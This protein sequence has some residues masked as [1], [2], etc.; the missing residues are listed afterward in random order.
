MK[1]ISESWHD[2]IEPNTK[3]QAAYN[4]LKTAIVTLDLPP[5]T[6]LVERYIMERFDLSRTPMREAINRLYIEGF[7]SNF[8]GKGFVV[9]DFQ[10]RDFIDMYEVKEALESEAAAICCS[11][12]IPSV[13]TQIEDAYNKYESYC[14]KKLYIKSLMSD[15]DFHWAIVKGANNPYLEKEMSIIMDKTLKFF[16]IYYTEE[17]PE[18]INTLYLVHHKKILDAIKGDDPCAARRA[19]LEHSEIVKVDAR[20]DL[21]LK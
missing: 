1:V 20:N 3:Q 18:R 21:F 4:T 17:V 16:N 11:R 10:L 9:N 12:K 7:V 15:L 2:H 14:N 8:G 19:V 5:N 6:V 13:M